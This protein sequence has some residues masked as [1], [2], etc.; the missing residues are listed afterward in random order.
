MEGIAISKSDYKY[1]INLQDFNMVMSESR[2]QTNV[3]GLNPILG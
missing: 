3:I 2:P 1:P